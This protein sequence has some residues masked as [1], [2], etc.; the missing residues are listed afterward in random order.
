MNGINDEMKHINIDLVEKL[1][2]EGYD[3]DSAIVAML[4]NIYD[5][6]PKEHLVANYTGPM[7]I[8]YLKTEGG[9]VKSK[10]K[11]FNEVPNGAEEIDFINISDEVRRRFNKVKV[12]AIGDKNDLYKKM[13]RFLL[14]NPHV[15]REEILNAVEYYLSKTPEMYVRR[16][17]Y[18][19]YK[20]TGKSEVSDLSRCIDEYKNLDKASKDSTNFLNEGFDHEQLFE[21]TS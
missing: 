17:N 4:I 13:K 1:K 21:E 16:A 5:L 3:P 19:V 15:T 2:D 18:F 6:K 12:G 14:E 8:H 9:V 20:Q 11:I 7:L 10:Y